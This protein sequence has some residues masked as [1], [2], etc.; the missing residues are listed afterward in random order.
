MKS[1]TNAREQYAVAPPSVK[2]IRTKFCST[3]N[4]NIGKQLPSGAKPQA[5]A[6]FRWSCVK[7]SGARTC[8]SASVFGRK[9][10][11]QEMCR[12][13]CPE[14]YEVWHSSTLRRANNDSVVAKPIAC[15]FVAVEIGQHSTKIVT[16]QSHNS[17]LDRMYSK[18]C[19]FKGT[20]LQCENPVPV[21]APLR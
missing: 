18:L 19:G 14:T 20:L 15:A 9:V 2:C 13:G 5:S 3:Q 8:H 7:C 1:E 12:N 11:V 4:T 10:F 16:V 17:F 21:R 6:F